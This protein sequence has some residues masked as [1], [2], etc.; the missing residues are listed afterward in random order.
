MHWRVPLRRAMGRSR[1][2]TGGGGEGRGD[3]VARTGGGGE[4]GG[5]TS[6]RLGTDAE[7][8]DTSGKEEGDIN[9]GRSETVVADTKGGR[10]DEERS[11]ADWVDEK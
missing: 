2:E 7:E 5:S 8:G 4:E 9:T 3:D 1:S 6:D 10:D 11:S